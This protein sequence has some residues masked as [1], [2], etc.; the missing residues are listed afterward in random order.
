MPTLE[1]L[2]LEDGDKKKFTIAFPGDPST[3]LKIAGG[4]EVVTEGTEGLHVGK[5]SMITV[6]GTGGTLQNDEEE[7]E[8]ARAQMT[9][10]MVDSSGVL[11]LNS[12]GLKIVGQLVIGSSNQPS[13]RRP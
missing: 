10:T 4:T 13:S 2:A 5:G 1:L 6:S 11:T 8:M 9:I 3:T 7:T 12:A